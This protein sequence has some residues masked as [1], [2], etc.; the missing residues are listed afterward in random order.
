MKTDIKI[1]LYN[2][3]SRIFRVEILTPEETGSTVGVQFYEK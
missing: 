1:L 3:I 2:K